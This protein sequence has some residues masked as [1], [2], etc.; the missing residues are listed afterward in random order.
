MNKMRN[1]KETAKRHAP[2]LLTA[3]V[4]G[5]MVLAPELAWA[6][7]AQ[8]LPWE[9]PL[10]KLQDSLTGPVA[11]GVAIIGLVGCMAALIWGGEM[12]EFLRKMIMLVLVIAGLVTANGVISKLF[13][14]SGAVIA[15]EAG[16]EASPKAGPAGAGAW[17]AQPVALGVPA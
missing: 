8:G 2:A 9:S 14:A 3:A 5:F 6:G 16:F 7:S 15:A 17:R 11:M 4:A 13:S 12:N 1:L 10:Q